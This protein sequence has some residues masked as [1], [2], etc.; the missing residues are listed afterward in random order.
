MSYELDGAYQEKWKECAKSWKD[1]LR[2]GRTVYT[3]YTVL[4]RIG[5]SKV[6]VGRTVYIKIWKDCIYKELEGVC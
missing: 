6:R 1:V 2:L 5:R 4:K 3:L